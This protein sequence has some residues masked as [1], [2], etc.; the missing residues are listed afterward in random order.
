ME[1]ASAGIMPLE[2]V[3]DQTR[4]VMLEK[5]MPIDS[6]FPKGVEVFRD[7]EF[8]LVINM[9]GTLLPKGL[10]EKERRW[11]VVD[12]YGRS[13]GAFRQVRDDLE[14]RVA[15]LITELRENNGE[16]LPSKPR[17]TILGIP[18]GSRKS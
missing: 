8:D 14:E 2:S 5:G 4:K 16:V 13:D 1:V 9:S 3:P 10:K 11:T 7:T 18:I 12:P 6:Q 17:R 15:E